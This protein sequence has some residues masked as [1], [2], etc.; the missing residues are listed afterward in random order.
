MACRLLTEVQTSTTLP[1]IK[2]GS[3]VLS[4]NHCATMLAC[5][6]CAERDAASTGGGEQPAEGQEAACQE[7]GCC[8]ASSCL[9]VNTFEHCPHDNSCLLNKLIIQVQFLHDALPVPS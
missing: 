3:W 2:P 6:L 5:L 8:P 9:Q 7:G 4:C 1:L